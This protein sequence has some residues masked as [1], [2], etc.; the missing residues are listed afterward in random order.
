M[1][2]WYLKGCPA[3][4]PLHYYRCLLCPA[5][6]RGVGKPGT[7]RTC[8][9]WWAQARTWAPTHLVLR[10]E[11]PQLLQ[12]CCQ[13]RAAVTE[14]VWVCETCGCCVW[15]CCSRTDHLQQEQGHEESGRAGDRLQPEG[16]SMLSETALGCQRPQLF[17]AF[18]SPGART[19]H[20]QAKR[21]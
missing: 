8:R 21:R 20:C 9:V 16:V 13:L 11:E 1:A 6:P 18:T 7:C 5:L 10:C 14:G 3:L 17:G 15:K 2:K 19:G 12:W 4:L